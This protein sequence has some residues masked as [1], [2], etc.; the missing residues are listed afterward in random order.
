MVFGLLF[1]E[2]VGYRVGRGV[3]GILVVVG[4]LIKEIGFRDGGG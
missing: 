3:R 2:F 4:F 1:G